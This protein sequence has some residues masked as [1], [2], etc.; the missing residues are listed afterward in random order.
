M[1]FSE[2]LAARLRQVRAAL[3]LS[4]GEISRAIGGY[5]TDTWSRLERCDAIGI[6]VDMLLDLA[7]WTHKNGISQ[8]WLLAGKGPMWI[9]DREV[10]APA[11]SASVLAQPATKVVKRGRAPRGRPFEVR[12]VIERGYE[13]CQAEG[14]PEDWQG[15]W[16][17]ILGKIAAGAGIDTVAAENQP[18]GLADKFVKWPWGCDKPFAVEVVGDS[19]EPE[20][21]D[22][23]V[24]IVD[25][26]RPASGGVCCVILAQDGERLVRLKRLRTSRGKVILESLNKK[27]YPPVTLSADRLVAAYEIAEHL[28][29]IKDLSAKKG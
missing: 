25:G 2:D 3:N 26:G 15:E 28:P 16:V 17:P 8:D 24:V 29:F 6:S 23:D 19:M 7:A 20:F 11:E 4:Q 10:R 12:R 5:R 14:L 21:F 22:H 9:K 13:T 1:G 27:K 18:A